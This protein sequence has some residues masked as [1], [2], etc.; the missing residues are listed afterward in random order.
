M[1]ASRPPPPSSPP[2][3]A[4]RPPAALAGGAGPPPSAG[5]ATGPQ[6]RAWQSNPTLLIGC[7]LDKAVPLVLGRRLQKDLQVEVDAGPLPNPERP[8]AVLQIMREFSF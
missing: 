4:R 3:R 7:T 2:S 5:Y 8:E 6:D 1:T